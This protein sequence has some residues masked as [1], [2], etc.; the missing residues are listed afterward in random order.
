M[1]A[2]FS[3]IIFAGLF[4][5]TLQH[6]AHAQCGTWQP[7]GGGTP[8]GTWPMIVHNNELV[9]G[10]F[11]TSMGGQTI[12]NV[13]RW[14]DSI[15]QPMNTTQLQL[16]NP[17][18][19]E[20]VQGSLYAG[21]T[22]F[23]GVKKLGGSGWVDVGQGVSSLFSHVVLA[24]AEYDGEVIAAGQFDGPP[25][26]IARWN[27]SVWQALGGGMN[28]GAFV[29]DLIVFEDDLIAG[30]LF[31][32]AG[33]QP[34]A[35]LARWD[36]ASW[37]SF[38]PAGGPNGTIYDLSI[39]DGQ[40]VV[41]GEFSSIGGVQ[42]KGIA[43]WD[44]KTWHP[45]GTGVVGK[46]RSA[47]WF[48]GDLVVAGDITMAGEVPV[49]RVARWNGKE[50]SAF[51]TGLPTDSGNVR[52]LAVYKNR[53]YVSGFFPELGSIARLIDCCETDL[54]GN[55]FTEVDDLLNVINNWGPCQDCPADITLNGEINVDDLLMVINA[56][57]PCT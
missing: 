9:V 27:G 39:H 16:A 56:W 6:G 51:E 29:F 48:N 54:T 11:F 57:G 13:A 5:G 44:G 2:M 36:G 25:G 20:H 52:K 50:W 40:L 42:A 24:F 23:K 21:G 17:S 32:T 55:G 14:N 46:V 35:S 19:F 30:G 26:N 31:S 49:D 10:G 38:S 1:R 7:V 15:W 53:L 34:I 12:Y 47:V 4:A 45:F 28:A 41:A 43:R 18:V 3:K 22:F 37:Q 33:G 8:D